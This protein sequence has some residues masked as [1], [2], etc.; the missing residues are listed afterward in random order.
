MKNKHLFLT[1]LAILLIPRVGEAG[2]LLNK[3]LP[4][5]L[6]LDLQFRHRYQYKKNVDF[7]DANDDD[8]GYQLYRTRLNVTLL[9]YD[10]LK[11]FYQLQDARISHDSKAVTTKFQDFADTRQL[12]VQGQLKDL[13]VGALTGVG[14]RFGR[15]ELSYGAERLLGGFNWSN[16]AQTFDAGKVMFG[17]DD[18]KLNV[19]FFAG[20]KTPNKAPREAD[21]LYDGSTHDLLAG[22]YATYKGIQNMVV[23]QYLLNRKTNKDVSF[24]PTG[25]GEI[26]DYTFG[27]RVKGK[28]P[29]SAVDYELEFARQIGNHN[30]LDVN[31]Q[32][33]VAIVGYTFKHDWKPRA[34]FE[35]DYGSGD[36]DSSDNE[37][38]TFDNLFPTN[39]M[40][41]GYMDFVSLQN[42]NNYRFQLSAKPMKKL[43]V[44]ADVHLIYL[45]TPK[46]DL[47]SAG[48]ATKRATK[49][50]AS[51]HVGNEIDLKAAYKICPNA[52]MLL[53]YSHFFAGN[54]LEDTGTADDA[55]YLYVQTVLNF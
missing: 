47:Y 31:A 15:Q 36:N 34:A 30:S 20:T 42:I 48:R 21:D 41:Y 23:E 9:P 5:W 35:F 18:L 4:D 46:D 14:V 25:A 54:F 52:N 7:N 40:H 19:D 16:I 17:F 37:R 50:N 33:A 27:F 24:G 45:D 43:K 10:G 11:F 26:E 3:H 53:G 22:Y 39:H 49:P 51:T 8:K 12:W 32:M 6:R 29:D 28:V 2:E 13:N 55:D 1:L 38:R 44:Q